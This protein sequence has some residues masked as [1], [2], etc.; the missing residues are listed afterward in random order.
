[1]MIM[2]WYKITNISKEIRVTWRHFENFFSFWYFFKNFFKNFFFI[3]LDV[4]FE[5]IN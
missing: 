4:Y 5:I 1:M 2:Y 3:V